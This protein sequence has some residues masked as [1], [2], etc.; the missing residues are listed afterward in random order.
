[1]G[2][3][4]HRATRTPPSQK[5]SQGQQAG[6]SLIPEA[7]PGNHRWM[8]APHRFPMLT[9]MY[10]YMHA[11]FICTVPSVH[12]GTLSILSI[13][14]VFAECGISDEKQIHE[15]LRAAASGPY[16]ENFPLQS[17]F[18][19]VWGWC[20][21]R[22]H[23]ALCGQAVESS[24]TFEASGG[25]SR[26]PPTLHLPSRCVCA[27]GSAYL[28]TWGFPAVLAVKNPAASAG[29]RRDTGSV[30]GWGRS[31]GERAWQPTPV[32]LPGESHGQRSLAG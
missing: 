29:D 24:G 7:D 4:G 20:P 9:Y 12:Q 11:Y 13:Q 19:L 32:F 27:F 6:S 25:C 2:S 8:S 30:P 17:S 3:T 16:L 14:G 23:C 22:R 1:M 18:P 10:T 31:S 5:I 28:Q 26:S 21:C 15:C